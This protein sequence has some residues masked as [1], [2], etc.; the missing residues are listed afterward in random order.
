MQGD[1][2]LARLDKYINQTGIKLI[3]EIDTPAVV[4]DLDITEANIRRFQDYCDRNGLHLRPHIKTHKIPAIAFAQVKA[5]AVGINCQKV[6]EAEVMADAGIAD[7]LITYNILGAEKLAV[8]PIAWWRKNGIGITELSANCGGCR[9]KREG[10]LTRC[11][12]PDRD[13]ERCEE[14]AAACLEEAL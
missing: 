11:A 14:N 6:S 7:I 2:V 3:E 10:L 12:G 8:F 5:G 1:D 9:R 13:G 4:V